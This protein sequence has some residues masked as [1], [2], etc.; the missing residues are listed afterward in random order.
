MNKSEN[1]R[2]SSIEGGS[3]GRQRERG[4]EREGW[5]YCTSFTSAH[6]GLVSS[7]Q[8]SVAYPCVGELRRCAL[9]CCVLKTPSLQLTQLI[10]LWFSLLKV[11]WPCFAMMEKLLFSFLVISVWIFSSQAKGLFLFIYIFTRHNCHIM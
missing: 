10:I 7:S 9:T 5:D 3:S 1:I 8:D 6:C 2:R 11:Q 4:S